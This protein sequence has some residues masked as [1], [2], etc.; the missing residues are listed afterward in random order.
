MVGNH[1]TTVF[2]QLN[3]AFPNSYQFPTPFLRHQQRGS[4]VTRPDLAKRLRSSKACTPARLQWDG[5]QISC[6]TLVW[7]NMKVLTSAF[8]HA[9]GPRSP[10]TVDSPDAPYFSYSHRSCAIPGCAPECRGS[11]AEDDLPASTHLQLEFFMKAPPPP[12]QDQ[13]QRLIPCLRTA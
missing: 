2:L 4:L 3:Y 10:R 6:E 9:S 11:R 8:A 5:E 1:F 12:S 7:A 13:S